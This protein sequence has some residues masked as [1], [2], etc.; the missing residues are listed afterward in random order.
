VNS[1]FYSLKTKMNW[2]FELINFRPFRFW[3]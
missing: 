1:K 3:Q 2:A